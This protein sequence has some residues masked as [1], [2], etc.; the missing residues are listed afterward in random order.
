MSFTGTPH[1]GALSAQDFYKSALVESDASKRR[2]LFADARQSNPRS[3]QIWVKAAE[4]EEHWGADEIKL[5]DLLL[6]GLVVFRN[7]ADS[8]CTQSHD[9]SQHGLSSGAISG[10]TWLAEANLAEEAGKTKTANALR[11]AVSED[12]PN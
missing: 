11:L 5:K 9:H 2:R 3:Y 7:P 4:V 10:A 1:G 8:S 12:S 6:K